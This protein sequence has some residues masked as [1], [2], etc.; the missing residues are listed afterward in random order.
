MGHKD[1]GQPVVFHEGLQKKSNE[2]NKT[3]KFL[4]FE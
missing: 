3:S 2:I 4:F 1:Q